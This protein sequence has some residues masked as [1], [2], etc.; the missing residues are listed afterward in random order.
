MP[1]ENEDEEAQVLLVESNAPPAPPTW[2]KWAALGVVLVQN[3]AHV[4]LL[5][6]TRVA[7]GGCAEYIASIVVL[8]SEA[9]KLVFC[10]LLAVLLGQGEHL[11]ALFGARRVDTLKLGV[12]ALCFALQNN[13]QFVAASHL[14]PGLLQMANQTKTIATA[15]FGI[16]LLDRWLSKTQW[17]AIAILVVGV[18]TAQWQTPT[19]DGSDVAVGLAASF[20]VSTSSGFASVYLER[21]L[22]GDDTSIW[23]RNVQLCLFSIPLQIVTIGVRDADRVRTLGPLHGFCASTW[24]T[25][26]MF[27]FGGIVVAVVIRVADNNLKNFAMAGSIV[28]SLGVSIPLF[29]FRA[30]PL[31]CVGAGL[32]IGSIF[33]YAR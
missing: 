21:I 12:P 13:M 32:V 28:L 16:A 3:S 8:F 30:T 2:T 10:T 9:L 33:L 18:V 14:S 31:F 6:Y 26:A 29:G 11:L 20:V 24:A 17:V 4:L 22:K 7:G 25:V 5:R 27:A 19:D 15:L 23:V 1:R